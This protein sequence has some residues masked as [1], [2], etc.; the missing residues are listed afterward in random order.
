MSFQLNN[1]S[2]TQQCNREHEIANCSISSLS[3]CDSQKWPGH[4]T[5]PKTVLNDSISIFWT[6]LS[7]TISAILAR[8]PNAIKLQK[9]EEREQ[10]FAFK[11]SSEI[12]LKWWVKQIS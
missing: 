11:I 3:S 7:L 8:E 9:L 5:E 2:Q 10:V 12:Y 4:E 6:H 1:M